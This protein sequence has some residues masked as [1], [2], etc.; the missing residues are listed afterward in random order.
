MSTA[1]YKLLSRI[2]YYFYS[3]YKSQTIFSHREKLAI[4]IMR[5]ILLTRRVLRRSFADVVK[6]DAFHLRASLTRVS[7]AHSFSKNIQRSY[8]YD[9]QQR[10]H[11]R[12]DEVYP[13][14]RVHACGVK[15]SNGFEISARPVVNERS[16]G[17]TTDVRVPSYAGHGVQNRRAPPSPPTPPSRSSLGRA[18]LQVQRLGVYAT[19]TI[20]LCLRLWGRPKG[21]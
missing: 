6:T 4:A 7:L 18:T 13:F 12:R 17:D 21:C 3:R 19:E 1:N 5:S 2:S 11:C 8:R 20:A 10:Y 14:D 16:R 9:G 15:K